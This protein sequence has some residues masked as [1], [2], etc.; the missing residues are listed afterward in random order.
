MQRESICRRAFDESVSC[1]DADRGFGVQDASGKKRAA[2][3][4][5]RRI[6]IPLLV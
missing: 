5:A 3:W 6:E 1:R 4:A 2:S